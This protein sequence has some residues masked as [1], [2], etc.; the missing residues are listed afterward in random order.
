MSKRT[1][2]NH[3]E[4]ERHVTEL[5]SLPQEQPARRDSGIST[6]SSLFGPR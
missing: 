6:A 2:G 4:L 5:T 1:P 3:H